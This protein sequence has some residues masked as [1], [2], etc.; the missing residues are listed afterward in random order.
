VYVYVCVFMRLFDL[1]KR[2]HSSLFFSDYPRGEDRRESH[3]GRERTSSDAGQS[4]VPRTLPPNFTIVGE[5]K[6]RDREKPISKDKPTKRRIM[7]VVR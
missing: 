5:A 3:H 6:A 7:E 1:S 2:S 4:P